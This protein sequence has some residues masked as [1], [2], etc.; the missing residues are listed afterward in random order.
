MAADRAADA[1]WRILIVDDEENLTWSLVTSLRKDGYIVDGAH[2]GEEALMRLQ[3]A[4]YDCVISDIRMPGMDGFELLQ[5]LRQHR[6]T[7]RVVMMTSFG[8]PSTRQDV[9]R[10]GAIAYFEKPFDLRALKEQVR[11]MAKTPAATTGGPEVGYDLLDVAQVINLSRRDAALEVRSGGYGGVLR[12][13]QGELL[14]A[15]AGD[16]RGDEAFL[17]LCVPRGGRA[18]IVPWNGYTA[19][20]VTQPLARLIYA[21][22]A[23][24]EGRITPSTRQAS[25]PPAPYTAPAAPPAFDMPAREAAMEAPPMFGSA[26]GPP[27]AAGG[28]GADPSTLPATATAGFAHPGP[29]MPASDVPD[30][31]YAYGAGQDTAD[32]RYTPDPAPVASPAEAPRATPGQALDPA[33][34]L[35]ALARA[36]PPPCGV[37]WIGSDAQLIWQQ[38]HGQPGLPPEALAH[39]HTAI[40][41]AG[42]ASALGE[43]GA[44]A[45]LRIAAAGRQIV[46]RR[47]PQGGT[48]LLSLAPNADAASITQ[49]LHSVLASLAR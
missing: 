42:Q 39:L 45:E 40:R 4:P 38:W 44:L 26:G 3:A 7:T 15:E 9:L 36:L 37:V 19:R 23:R 21:A 11:R 47:G 22:L 41:E 48:L 6:P 35:D 18:Q 49:T 1:P 12:F 30:A 25:D 13:T 24:R 14:W 29:A 46:L 43:L 5:W 10:D 2:T 34:A 33:S 8:S 16:L 32:Y 31:G 27:F 28:P 20:N 17:A